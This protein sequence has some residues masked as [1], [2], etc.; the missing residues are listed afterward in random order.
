MNEPNKPSDGGPAFP[1][2]F[3]PSNDPEGLFRGMCLL[4]WF[5][6][7]ALIGVL[8]SDTRQEIKNA[9]AAA[10]SYDQAEA[11]LAEREKRRKQ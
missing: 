2:D 10:W 8:A 7:Q 11:M 1:T 5:A 9:D 6:G 3:H 4:D